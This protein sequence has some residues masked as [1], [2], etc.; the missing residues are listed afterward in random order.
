M[1]GSNLTRPCIPIA[2]PPQNTLS[3]FVYSG[4]VTLFQWTAKSSRSEAT[5]HQQKRTFTISPDNWFHAGI[6]FLDSIS[7]LLSLWASPNLDAISNKKNEPVRKSENIHT[8][9]LCL[10]VD[11]FW[12]RRHFC[13]DRKRWNQNYEEKKKRMTDE[14]V[15]VK[16]EK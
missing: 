9:P 12:S 11:R 4:Q 14:K 16:K 5:A 1:C 2:N 6:M 7:L 10:L 15:E 8:D 3:R 13:E